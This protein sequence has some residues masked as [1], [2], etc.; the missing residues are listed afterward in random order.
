[1]LGLGNPQQLPSVTKNLLVIN[2]LIF[3]VMLLSPLM[4]QKLTTYAALHY[5]TSPGFK[6][7]QLVTYMF[8]HGGFG[9][10]LF[11]MIALYFFG[12]PIERVLGKERFLFFYL[13]CGIGAALVQEGVFAWL[14]HG[15]D[16]K[17]GSAAVA[18]VIDHSWAMFSNGSTALS[19]DALMEGV[20]YGVITI[21]DGGYSF[22]PRVMELIG[23]ANTPTV[24]ASGAIF[25]ILGAAA[26]LFP[27]ARVYLYFAI[28]MKLKWLVVGYAVLELIQGIG[29]YATTVAHFAHLGGLLVSILLVLYW[30][31]KG[32]FND[33]WFF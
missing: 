18:W 6:L 28:P 23:I 8:V 7:W 30:K 33:K 10:L 25:G 13:T 27:N 3:V 2:V 20:R 1:M 14:I 11:N 19:G 32:F 15:F 17:Y 5:F 24:G 16:V 29:G 22:V 12:P 21:G 4:D 26:M 31:K 9:H